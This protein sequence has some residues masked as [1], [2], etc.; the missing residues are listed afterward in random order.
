MET[1]SFECPMLGSLHLPF[2]GKFWEIGDLTKAWTSP[3]EGEE[4]LCTGQV[5]VFSKTLNPQTNP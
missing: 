3:Y 1:L 2:E 5:A 4:L